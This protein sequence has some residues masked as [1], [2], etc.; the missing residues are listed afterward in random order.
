M[1]A[2]PCPEWI[3]LGIP[4]LFLLHLHLQPFIDQCH[5]SFIIHQLIHHPQNIPSTLLLRV[6]VLRVFIA[7][8]KLEFL[9][10]DI[11]AEEEEIWMKMNLVEEDDSIHEE[12]LL[13]SP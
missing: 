11:P 9:I 6:L 8:R 12:V 7:G 2:F 1:V 5:P 4:L 10:W 13:G 3:P